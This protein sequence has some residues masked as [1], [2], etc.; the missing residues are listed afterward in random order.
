MKSIIYE[1]DPVIYPFPLLVSKQFDIHELRDRFYVALN[2][3][4][5]AP[6]EHELDKSPTRTAVT[7]LVVEKR[8]SKVFFLVLFYQLNR[9]NVGIIAHEAFHVNTMNCDFLGI[10]P[11]VPNND[12]PQAYF[13]QWAADCV[14][15]VLKNR[16]DEL[17]AKRFGNEDE[18]V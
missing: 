3:E 17:N 13:V 2:K 5:V 16:Q 6:I 4:D 8:T 15:S 9:I 1:F 14:N 11:A 7:M 12:E 18:K 10:G